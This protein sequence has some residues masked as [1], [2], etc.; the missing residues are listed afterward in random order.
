MTS[1]MV[2]VRRMFT[3][4]YPHAHLFADVDPD[5]KHGA[6]Y[7]DR[8][9][10][11]IVTDSNPFD[12]SEFV[13]LLAQRIRVLNPFIRQLMLSWV[14]VLYTVPD[15]YLLPHL[16]KLLEGLFAMLADSNRDIRH[17]ADACLSC[18]LEDLQTEALIAKGSQVDTAKPV[19][20]GGVSRDVCVE[21]LRISLRTCKSSESFC[22]LTALVWLHELVSKLDQDAMESVY[23][24]ILDGLLHSLSDTEEEISRIAHQTHSAL[25]SQ[26][27]ATTQLCPVDLLIDVL[28]DHLR[29]DA[30]PEK[31]ACMEWLS[32]LLS[33]RADKALPQM[34]D[35]VYH[36]LS[37]LKHSDVQV[38]TS[39][40][41]VLVQMSENGDNFGK[42]A[43]KLLAL[44]AEDTPQ[45]NRRWCL[46]IRQ[47][48]SQLDV[49]KI[50]TTVAQAI[51]KLEDLA[52][53]H[54]IV[55]LFNW[56]LLTAK[57]TN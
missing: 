53:S 46:V 14:T 19:V 32:L 16:P 47:L 23:P 3:R 43:T 10:K 15:V 45:L 42:I 52:Y 6:Q 9:I 8:L 2:Y 20:V 31:V 29:S 48:C 56:I 34:D 11:D 51:D 13:P 57:V 18:F 50:Y 28:R 25:L 55:H 44:F 39:A 35:L 1:L 54:Q 40:M 24:D 26:V 30:V 17:A 12:V 4:T 49:R 37:S 41:R 7:L 27:S 21:L 5:V 33:V 36:I 22:R 38:L